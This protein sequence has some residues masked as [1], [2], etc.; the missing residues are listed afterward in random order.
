IHTSVDGT[1]DL[2]VPDNVRIYL[3]ASTQHLPFPFPPDRRRIAGANGRNDGEALSNP[4][5]QNNTMR[6]L[7]RALHQWAAGG[8]PPPPSEYPRL[9]DATLVPVAQ[10]R[11]PKLPGV[12]DPRQITGPARRRD[13]RVVPLPFL[14]PQVDADG[15][16][17]AG[18]HD[19][20]IA[21]PLAT[22]T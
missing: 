1:R 14:V 7:L 12:S 4:V 2:T 16:D 9:R 5:P 11:F 3:L 19:P 18:I 8:V 20:V 22:A 13:G 21:V 15:N 6:A 10:A 17:I